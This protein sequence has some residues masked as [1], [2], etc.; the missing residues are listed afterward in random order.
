MSSAK[1]LSY[2][3]AHPVTHIM[4]KYVSQVLGPGT[5]GEESGRHFKQ[6]Q[7]LWIYAADAM[8]GKTLTQTHHTCEKLAGQSET[9]GI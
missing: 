4:V 5:Y 6:Y 7:T 3:L 8:R 2:C 1:G 9:K